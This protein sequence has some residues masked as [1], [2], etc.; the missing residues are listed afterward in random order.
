MCEPAV[1]FYCQHVLGMGHLVRSLALARALAGRFRVV[2]LNGGAVPRGLRRPAGIEFVDLPPLGFD[3]TGQ[4][5]SRNAGRSVE[6]AQ[7]E[8]RATILRTFRDLRPRAVVVELFPFGRKKFAEE[9]LPL[10]EEGRALGAQRPLLVSSLRDILATGRHDQARHDERA[11]MLA[12]RYLDAILVHAD[13]RFARLEESFRPEQELRV[14]VYYTGF[15]VTDTTRRRKP[16]RRRH[17]IVSAGGGLV[18][19]PLFRAA[20]QAHALLWAR[21]RLRTTV[22]AGPCLPQSEGRALGGAAHGR[23]PRRDAR[24]G[25]THAS[26]DRRSSRMSQWLDP[27]RR[28]LDEA[29]ARLAFF[30]RDDDVGRAD[31]RLH[32]L[33]DLFS[34]HAVPIDLAVIPQALAPAVADVLCTRIARASTP[35]GVHVHGFAHVNHEPAGRKCEFGP[36]RD[37]AAQRRD[38]ELGRRRVA[39]LLGDAVAPFFTPPWN[40]CTET[41]GR[42]LRQ[43][44][45]LVLS[46]AAAEP[47]FCLPRLLEMPVRLYSL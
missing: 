28:V 38:L 13:P 18:G 6:R 19:G 8:R 41:T 31:E 35:I 24:P 3:A 37:L 22:V 5:V 34:R 7:R 43:L 40:R 10:F 2:F 23:D 20:V 26:A 33:L 47:P 16:R 45:F 12:N 39:E 42:L 15:V 25:G 1:L 27:L 11:C 4:L 21:E 46:P 17:L 9:L 14:P 30:F 32:P 29:P 36:A 44:G